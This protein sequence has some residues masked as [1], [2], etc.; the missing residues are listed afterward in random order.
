MALLPIQEPGYEVE[1]RSPS[2]ELGG[3]GISLW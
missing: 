2:G 3:P 1:V